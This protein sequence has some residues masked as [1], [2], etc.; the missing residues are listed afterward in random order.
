MKLTALGSGY[1]RVFKNGDEVS[2]HNSEREA[3]ES[4]INMELADPSAVM[5]I[6]HD[7]EVRVEASVPVP[8]PI[9][10]PAPAPAP[11]SQAYPFRAD[12]W[13]YKKGPVVARPDSAAIVTDLALWAKDVA[14]G[15]KAA[16][17]PTIAFSNW[18]TPI[19]HVT[20]PAVP[21]KTVVYST[22]LGKSVQIRVPDNIFA[23]GG[24]DQHC[25][26]FDWVDRV[27]VDM[28]KFD[29]VTLKAVHGGM[30]ADF[31]ASDATFPHPMGARACGIAASAGVITL[32]A[33]EKGVHEGMVAIAVPRTML[34][35]KW[36]ANRVDKGANIVYTGLVQ[37]G[38]ILRLQPSFV[39]NSAW[40]PI[41]KI[42]S[43]AY[44]DY[45][46]V[47][48]DTTG[49]SCINMAYIEDPRMKG[50]TFAEIKAAYYG[51][52]DT[53]KMGQMFP[54]SKLEAVQ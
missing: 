25:A 32:E 36:P 47:V 23:A 14:S 21:K 27:F 45:G 38:Q 6:K 41:M 42:Y 30:I 1:Y 49:G 19:I 39:P 18:S 3:M 7:Y 54:W 4:A 10:E 8:A 50:K 46:A 29:P 35:P 31:P 34:T 5:T 16:A 48:V 26:I 15:G 51:G 43:T 22:N 33:L 9:P 40:P 53:W 2:K 52:L 24:G 20:D 44:R 28:W 12:S 11:T 37:M 17:F 13:L